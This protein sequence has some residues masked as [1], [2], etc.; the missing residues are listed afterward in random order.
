MLSRG[1]H[2]GP[3]N[4]QYFSTEKPEQRGCARNEKEG[5]LG[6]TNSGVPRIGA[7][8]FLIMTTEFHGSRDLAA[9]MS[10]ISWLI[11]DPLYRGNRRLLVH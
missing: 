11:D 3:G 10:S 6:R 5:F 8:L 1:F 4:L 9:T 2:K 7:Y